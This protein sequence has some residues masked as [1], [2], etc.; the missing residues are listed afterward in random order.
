[1]FSFEESMI[2]K[3]P[4]KEYKINIATQFLNGNPGLN[5]QHDVRV[6]K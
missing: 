4:L 6:Q 2:M 5:V 1:M 3:I